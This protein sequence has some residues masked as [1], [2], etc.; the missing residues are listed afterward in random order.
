MCADANGAR[1]WGMQSHRE[2]RAR[3]AA[4]MSTTWPH[5]HPVKDFA[6]FNQPLLIPLD[7]F[8]N[9]RLVLF[10]ETGNT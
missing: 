3:R 6:P 10:T 5:D 8:R 1:L 9:A 2:P 7:R 4:S